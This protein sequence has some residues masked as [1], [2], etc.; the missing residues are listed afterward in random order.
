M[1]DVVANPKDTHLTAFFKLCQTDRLAK[2]LLYAEVPSYFTW[3]NNK[4]NKRQKGKQGEVK[5]FPGYF[6]DDALGRVYTVHPGQQECF[7]LRILLHEVR[8]PTSFKALKTVNGQVCQTYREAC[9][10]LGLLED[11]A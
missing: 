11:D 5:D 2:T 10:K 8:G 9:N 6:K 1:A 7:F 4:W 3:S